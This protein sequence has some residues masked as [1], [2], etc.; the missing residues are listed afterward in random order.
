MCDDKKII[1]RKVA[2]LLRFIAKKIERNPE[3]LN[4][5]NLDIEELPKPVKKRSRSNVIEINVFEIYTK[6]GEDGLIQELEKLSISQLKHII[7]QNGF[8]PS[9]LSVKWKKKDRLLNLIV[10]KV[11]SRSEKG[12]VFK[13]YD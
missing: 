6:K 3:I 1:A 7:R 8:D 9:K 11:K 13:N 4:D 2:K 5:L 10:N 12:Q